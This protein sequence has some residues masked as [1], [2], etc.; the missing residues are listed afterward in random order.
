MAGQEVG[1]EV[2]FDDEFDRQTQLLRVGQILGD[3][4]LRVDND[5]ASSGFV[6]Y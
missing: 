1:V 3:V 2:R 6:G 4:P 5:C